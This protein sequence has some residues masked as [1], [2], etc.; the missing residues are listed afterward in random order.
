MSPGERLVVVDGSQTRTVVD[1]LLN[2]VRYGF[3]IRAV[4]Q[5][6]A[7]PASNPVLAT[8]EAGDEPA[9]AG[10]IVRYKPSTPI[11]EMPGVATGSSAVLDVDLEPG[12]AIGF[13]LR[14]VEFSEPLPVTSAEIVAEQ[15]EESPAVLSAEPD[16]VIELEGFSS[17][18]AGEQPLGVGGSGSSLP[19][20]RGILG[21]RAPTSAVSNGVRPN[22][23]QTGATWGID[24]IDQRSLPRD[25]RYEYDS[26]GTGVDVYVVDSGI[27]PHNEF[28]ARL[29]SGHTQIVDG[30]GTS[31]CSG[32]G[33]HVAG[34]VGGST[35]GVAK[36]VNLVPVRV[37][38][39]SGFTLTSL[40][41]NA[42]NW[43]IEHHTTRPAVVTLSLGGEPSTFLDDAVR[44]TI[45]DKITVVV[46]AGNDGEPSCNSSPARVTEAI[47][48]NASTS[49]DGRASFSNYGSCSDIYAPG[50]LILS[51]GYTSPTAT[52]TMSGTSMATPHVAGVAARWLGI[53]PV[54][55]PAQVW[56]RIDADHTYFDVGLGAYGDPKK[57]LYVSPTSMF[58][59]PGAPTGASA[60]PGNRTIAV[61]WTAPSSDGGSPITRYGA[62]A[63]IASTGAFA[64]QCLTTATNCTITGLTNG[65]QYRIHTYAENTA[66][67]SPPS[68]PV[69]ATPS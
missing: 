19:T 56:N 60:T 5:F 39:C 38:E 41:V 47:T 8:P 45:N 34:T 26:D 32:H 50:H 51:A 16:Y 15:L 48:V 23:V 68:T 20:F 21:M 3:S 13:G 49:S 11:T 40:V 36:G 55:T 65:T 17:Q 43:V 67:W 22:G 12:K 64:A 53:N 28:G 29:L 2:G 58:T 4:N 46:A 66:G 69:T 27:R 18:F 14:T 42:L 37:F 31:D 9:I 61:S 63:F 33:T 1:D 59:V 24:R 30:R 44:A 6:G 7:S 62:N 25:D 57:L 54:W 52:S 10:L 35:Y